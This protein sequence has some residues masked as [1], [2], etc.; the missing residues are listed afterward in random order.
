MMNDSFFAVLDP[1]LSPASPQA[2]AL[3]DLFGVTLIVCGVIF[4]LI[5]GLIAWCLVRFRDRAGN[6]EPNQTTGNSKMEIGWTVASA[7]VLVFLFVLTARAMQVSDPAPLRGSDLTVIGHQWWWEI[8]Y[9]D[10]TVTANEIHIPI[11]SDILVGIGSA[12]VIHSFWVPQLG[13]KIEAI[14][15]RVNQIWI[16]ADHP[17]EYFGTCAEFCGEQHAWMRILVIAQ[18]PDEF[19]AWLKQE[20]VR[21]PPAE[22][23]A[24][25]MGETFFR[26]QACMVCHDVGGDHANTPVGPDL[27]HFAGRR[28]I[29]AGVAPNT[30][31]DLR[32]W[33]KNPQQV[34]PGCHMPDF[35]LTPTEVEDLRA[36]LDTLK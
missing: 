29:G 16:R 22:S 2:K 1:V 3:S 4:L 20:A 15:G 5:V 18:P 33:L 28:T 25:G 36:Y 7:L 12:D 14:P 35:R 10:G 19:K 31:T 30:D 17:G 32:R 21:A 9:P 23:G 34:K 26:E 8:R 11:G 6:P 24:A 27:T 13:R